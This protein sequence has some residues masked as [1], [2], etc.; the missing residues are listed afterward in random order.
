MDDLI[1]GAGGAGAN[2][3]LQAGRSID[4]QANIFTDK[5]SLFLFAND[6]GATTDRDPGAA[7]ITM[8]SGKILDAGLGNI[9]ITMGARTGTNG[10]ISLASIRAANLNIASLLTGTSITTSGFISFGSGSLSNVTWTNSGIAVWDKNGTSGF[11]MSNAKI[12]NTGIFKI[13]VIDAGGQTVSLSDTTSF[14]TNQGLL[15]IDS[16]AGTDT[17]D[18]G[19]NFTNQGGAIAIHSGSFGLGGADLTLDAGSSLQGNGTFLGNVIN[20][21]GTVTAGVAFDFVGAFSTGTLTITGD[22]TQNANGRLLIK[23]DTTVDGLQSDVFNIGGTFD[24]KGGDIAFIPINNATVLEIALMVGQTFVP[25]NLNPISPNSV[26][27]TSKTIP[28]G[29]DVTVSAGGIFTVIATSATL[30]QLSAELDRLIE[31]GEFSVEEYFYQV[32][33]LRQLIIDRKTEEIRLAQLVC[34]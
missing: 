5:G 28:P 3:T 15:I 4:I 12:V 31:Q 11:T 20:D 21:A 18:F 22:Y 2:L 33:L 25:F 30:S 6:I 7:Q 34:K 27:F 16:V 1:V 26:A 19:L 10:N 13:N 17:V 23:L 14:F 24:V 29:L 32:A 9:D 8:A